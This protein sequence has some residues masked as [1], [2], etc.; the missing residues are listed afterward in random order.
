MDVQSTNLID[1][2]SVLPNWQSKNKRKLL[3]LMEWNGKEP[4]LDPLVAGLKRRTNYKCKLQENSEN[5][6]N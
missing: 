1:N 2:S 6:Q 5:I 3:L 4:T